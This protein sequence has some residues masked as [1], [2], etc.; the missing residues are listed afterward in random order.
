[1]R[2]E[3]KLKSAPQL[4]EDASQHLW[5]VSY[6]DMLMVLM[7]F[8]IIYF[9]FDE[10]QGKKDPLAALEFIL[11]SKHSQVPVAGS[12]VSGK[13]GEGTEN[14]HTRNPFVGQGDHSKL[15]VL[16]CDQAFGPGQHQLEG[17][18]FREFVELLSDVKPFI[19][20]GLKLIVVG[21]VDADSG[22]KTA[23]G[24]AVSSFTIAA[25]RAAEGANVA[26]PVTPGAV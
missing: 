6:A 15:T 23:S 17:A 4:E 13:P 25:L 3:V 22:E 10:L 18:A 20:N 11:K 8:F 5:A 2:R 1:M 7:S 12:L 26:V 19:G 14:G 16:L 21:H 24:E 9:Q